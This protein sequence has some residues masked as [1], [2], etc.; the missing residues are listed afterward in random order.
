MP[1]SREIR[2]L[3]RGAFDD[4]RFV[5][6]VQRSDGTIE[7]VD[8]SAMLALWRGKRVKLSIEEIIV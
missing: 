7:V 3:L 5:I 8:V 1:L 6:E 4:Q 2:G